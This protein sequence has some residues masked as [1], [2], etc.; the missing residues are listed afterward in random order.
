MCKAVSNI[1]EVKY[2]EKITFQTSQNHNCFMHSVDPNNAFDLNYCRSLAF[3]EHLK[4]ISNQ[5]SS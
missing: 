4:S 1:E 2:Y 5:G 3:N